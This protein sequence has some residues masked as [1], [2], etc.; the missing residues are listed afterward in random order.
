MINMCLVLDYKHQGR[1]E[2]QIQDFLRGKGWW[3]VPWDCRI[4]GALPTKR[5][6]V[7]TGPRLNTFSPEILAML[8]VE[9][10][11]RHQSRVFVFFC[12]DTRNRFPFLF[13]FLLQ[14]LV[15]SHLV[16]HSHFWEKIF[17]LLMECWFEFVRHGAGT[18][19]SRFSMSRIVHFSYERSLLPT[20]QFK[21]A[22]IPSWGSACVLPLQH[23]SIRTRKELVLASIPLV[24]AYL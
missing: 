3:L 5:C 23:T 2:I 21:H 6:N 16:W 7:R 11:I 19:S 14:N 1:I 8:K 13:F 9:I 22:S 10:T 4:D 18:T 12:H 20:T 17:F 15:P 24:C